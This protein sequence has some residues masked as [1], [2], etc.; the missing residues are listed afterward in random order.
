M[1]VHFVGENNGVK[2]DVFVSLQPDLAMHQ[3]S[4][5]AEK[6][7][8]LLLRIGLVDDSHVYIDVGV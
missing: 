7:K 2:V 3:A 8:N 1:T 4:R 6:A 5:V